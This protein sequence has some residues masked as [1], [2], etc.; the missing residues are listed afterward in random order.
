MSCL[1]VCNSSEV[2]IN[3]E[4]GDLIAAYKTHPYK[5]IQRRGAEAR[6]RG[7]NLR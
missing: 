7:E 5:Q 2:S 6:R 3:F 4:S 1:I